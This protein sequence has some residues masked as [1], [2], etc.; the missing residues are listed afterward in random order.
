MPVGYLFDNL[1]RLNDI[2]FGDD[3]LDSFATDLIFKMIRGSARDDSTAI[4]DNNVIC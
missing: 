3:D 1:F 4:D 2:S